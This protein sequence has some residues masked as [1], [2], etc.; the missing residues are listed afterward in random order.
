ML[1]IELKFYGDDKDGEPTEK[2]F[3]TFV[4]CN[5]IVAYGFESSFAITANEPELLDM[6]KYE[7]AKREEKEELTKYG[8]YADRLII[9]KFH[10]CPICGK[11][12]L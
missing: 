5:H 12:M 7:K 10:F 3:T 1:S 6:D 2:T 11:E 8:N 4:E 9:L